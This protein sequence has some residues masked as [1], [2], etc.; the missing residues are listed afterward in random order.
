MLRECA[1]VRRRRGYRQHGYSESLKR[2]WDLRLTTG[3]SLRRHTPEAIW[4]DAWNFDSGANV[5]QNVREFRSALVGVAIELPLNHIE[6]RSGRRN[7]GG[8]GL[9]WQGSL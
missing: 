4:L 9:P 1:I 2:G 8:A 7:V 6:S 5:P 3:A